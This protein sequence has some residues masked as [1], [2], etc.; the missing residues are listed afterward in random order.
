[1]SQKRRRRSA[2]EMW[3]IVL[4]GVQGDIEVSELCRQEGISPAQYCDWGTQPMASAG[5]VPAAA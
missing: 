5:K 4:A 3:R 1:M 2:E